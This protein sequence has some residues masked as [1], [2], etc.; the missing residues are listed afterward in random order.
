MIAV[1]NISKHF[2]SIKALDRVSLQVS[3]QDIFGLI[4]PDSAG[5][6][7]LM[8]IICGLMDPDQ[9]QVRLMNQDP[10][11]IDRQNLGYMP[12]RF[13]LYG[14][15]TIEENIDFLGS[16]YSLKKSVIR[17]R[18]EEI[19]AITGL[20]AFENRL[21]NSLSGGMKQKLA[22]TCALITRPALLILDR[23][24]YGDEPQSRQE[25]WRILY[26]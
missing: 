9:G 22:L 8:R 23:P 17:E 21:A 19:L 2:A 26:K 24:T 20:A 15:L 3:R 18:A 14:D 7:T 25:V 11:K 13:S 12:Q 4:G 10:E 6:T 16:L 5:K 1:D